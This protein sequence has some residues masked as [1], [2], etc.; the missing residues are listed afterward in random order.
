MSESLQPHGLSSTIS[1]SLLSFMS[2]ES[3]MLSNHFIPPATP[4]SFCPQSFPASVSFPV[5][6]PFALGGQS[7]EAS[8][9]ATILPMNIQGWFPLGLTGLISLQYR[10][11]SRAFSSTTIQKHQFSGSQPSLWFNSHIWE[12]DMITGKIIALTVWYWPSGNVHV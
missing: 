10:G 9:S 1:W 5:S 7:I 8:A 3:V 4:F 12:L 2:I 11:F 6:W